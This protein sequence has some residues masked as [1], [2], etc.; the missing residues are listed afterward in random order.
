MVERLNIRCHSC[1]GRMEV[2]W[3]PGHR[4]YLACTGTCHGTV[5]ADVFRQWIVGG[6][7]PPSIDVGVQLEE[8]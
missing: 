8:N 4:Y 6:P 3:A 5:S 7:Q 1:K 2:R